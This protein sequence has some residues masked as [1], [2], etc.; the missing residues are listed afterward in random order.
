MKRIVFDDG[1]RR[2]AGRGR[3]RGRAAMPRATRR[4][5]CTTLRAKMGHD[6]LRARVLELRGV[7]VEHGSGRAEE[8]HERERALHGRAERPDVRRRPQRQDL[9]SVLRR[10]Q[11]GQERVRQLRARRRP[12]RASQAEQ[13]SRPNPSRSCRGLRSQTGAQAF[14]ALYGKSATARNAYGKCV[15]AWARAQT[16]NEL[17]AAAECSTEQ[18]DATFAAAHGG[19]TFA[20]FYGTEPRSRTPSASASRRRRRRRARRSSRRRSPLPR[21]ACGE[22]NAN[23]AAFKTKYRTFGRCV[24]Q[25]ATQ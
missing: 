6:G 19:K 20:Q 21:R 1:A 9:R 14:T 13:Q 11:E 12:R 5:S 18:S 24:S 23:R 16:N 2:R 25:H 4:L 3:E 22:L 17:N 8:R 15:S 10:R 7:R